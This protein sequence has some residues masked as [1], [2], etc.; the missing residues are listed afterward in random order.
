M[1]P[2]EPF[3]SEV[4]KPAECDAVA[5][6]SPAKQPRRG[7]LAARRR[8]KAVDKPRPEE[9]SALLAW[10]YVEYQRLR[11]QGQP[12]DIPQW[13]A[14][15]PTCRSALRQV[16]E[17]EA[18][19]A[20]FLDRCRPSSGD[21]SI[22]WPR[23]G[24]ERADFT[25]LR[26][27]ARGA[28]A[29]VYLAT[30]ASTGGRLVVL[31]CSRHGDA[32]A[33]IL[34]RL[35][36]PNIVPI[37][38]AR[39]DERSGLTMVCMPYLGSATLE[40]VLDHL[41]AVEESPPRKASFFLEVTRFRAQPEDTPPPAVDPSLRHG[42]YTDGVIHLA[43]QLAET[44]AFLHQNGVCHRDLK[45]SNVLLDPAGKPLLLDFNL[46][47]SEREAAAPVGGTLRYMA[48][49]QIRSFL[50]PR[51]DSVD[52][53]VDFYALGVMIYELLGGVHPCSATLAESYR[54]SVARSMLT[55]L[56]G[57]FRPFREVCPE[58]ERPVAAVLDR[59]V[60]FEAMDRPGSAVELA[61]VL[62]R[63]FAPAQRL[64][65]WCTARRRWLLAMVSSLLLAVAVCAYDWSITT[66]YSQREYECGR[67]AYRAGDFDRA[68]SHFDRA[69]R[70]EPSNACFRHARGCARLQQSKYLPPD[71][72]RF[73][74]I[75]DDLTFTER[76]AADVCTL[77]V[78][79]YVQLR[80][81]E[82]DAAIKKY[83]LLHRSGYRSL[84]V[85]NNRAYGYFNRGRLQEAQ[86]DLEKA[87]QLDRH[88]Q[89]V[90]YNR[91]LIALQMQ[92]QRKLP[93]IPPQALEDI[94][95]AL[96]LG[97]KTSA[98]YRDAAILYAQAAG[99]DPHHS[100]SERALSY[101]RQA[102]AAGEPSGKFRSSPLLREALRHPDFSDLLRSVPPQASPPPELRLLDPV[103]LPN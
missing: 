75:L 40:D 78:H 60:A 91:A 65:R 47:E 82:Y 58:L 30:E 81:Q 66:P 1:T 69:L 21:E 13:C 41:L 7:R 14:R 95:E 10:A 98:L 43:A 73:D 39:L 37:L 93:A 74:R 85:L 57:G 103:D 97:P 38:S 72:V 16:L 34:G 17:V 80:N 26:E 79:A 6:I 20:S 2:A 54:P 76:G 61:A 67:I 48:P 86:N 32:E 62:K 55:D 49:E 99:N 12:P 63:Q 33:R 92:F 90:R 83:N 35:A 84:M 3:L 24:E 100:D 27:L 23:A 8:P 15:F 28:F 88:C 87:M 11:Q 50:D 9:K 68:E 44:L 36:H 64:R 45:P 19:A 25:I 52:A 94:K 4:P 5:V 96:R 101:L 70:A 102:L 71:Q 56:K 22:D 46:S 29:R 42:S 31:K 51:K 59:C 89:A 77:A 18:F 53:R